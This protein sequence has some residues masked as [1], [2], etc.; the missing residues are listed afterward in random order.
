M[1]IMKALLLVTVLSAACSV[2]RAA[3]CVN[4]MTIAPNW[5]FT[6]QATAG[7]A[8]SK[9][10][11]FQTPATFPA[12][13]T[14]ACSC[15]GEDNGKYAFGPKGT[16]ATATCI[17]R[18]TA[19]WNS[20]GNAYKGLDGDGC[21]ADADC[22]TALSCTSPTYASGQAPQTSKKCVGIAA[23]QTCTSSATCAFGVK[24]G[25]AGKCATASAIGEACEST[26]DCGGDFMLTCGTVA[27]T[28]Q[29][30]KKYSQENGVAVSSLLLCK[31]VFS[32]G[33][34][35]AAQPTAKATGAAC[36][37]HAD[38]FTNLP[39]GAATDAAFSTGGAMCL[40]KGSKDNVPGTCFNYA[41]D[42]ASM[43][44]AL[45]S[46]SQCTSDAK[47]SGSV[48]R[49]DSCMLKNC[50]TARAKLDCLTGKVGFEAFGIPSAAASKAMACAGCNEI[51]VSAATSTSASYSMMAMVT[52]LATLHLWH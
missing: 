39:T 24:C 6:C 45:K 23:G 31:S 14:A 36:S 19:Y 52:V 48:L 46:F 11:T 50:G 27:G 1:G 16:G 34:K 38:C 33:G 28:K 49:T 30:V 12:T 13:I 20:G 32:Y 47:C 40:C 21:T 41:S 2:A 44:S 42:D 15:K 37:R 22:H 35:C 18:D 8:C 9:D 7:G 5:A 29:C 4:P 51:L 25:D 3:L 10:P 17:N 43:I 26:A